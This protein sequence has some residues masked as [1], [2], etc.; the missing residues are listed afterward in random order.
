MMLL[1]QTEFSSSLRSILGPVTAI[2]STAAYEATNL[3]DRKTF[4]SYKTFASQKKPG[5]SGHNSL[6]VL[7][8]LICLKRLKAGMLSGYFWREI[9]HHNQEEM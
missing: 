1:F 6:V 4:I 7:L 8:L 3:S 9:E 2:N 5:Y